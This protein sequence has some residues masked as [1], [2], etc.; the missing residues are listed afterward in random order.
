[1]SKKK[2]WFERLG[3]SAG[4]WRISF[5]EESVEE[6][7]ERKENDQKRFAAIDRIYEIKE[8]GEDLM[9]TIMEIWENTPSPDLKLIEAKANVRQVA[10]FCDASI[11]ELQRP[12]A[13][14]TPQFLVKFNEELLSKAESVMDGM[15]NRNN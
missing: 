11:K 2:T 3:L 5:L 1:M 7:R 15:S 14:K 12:W 8:R 9:K 10:I 13:E 4:D 6:S